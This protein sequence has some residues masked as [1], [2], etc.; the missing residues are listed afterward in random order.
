MYKPRSAIQD[1]RK[2]SSLSPLPADLGCSR[3]RPLLSGRSRKHPTSAGGE[4]KK[5]SK[6]MRRTWPIVVIAG[7][8]VI[9]LS[10]GVRQVSGL[11]LR[12]VAIDIG[13]S[14]EAFGI[15]VAL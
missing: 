7:S 6:D 8:L 12:P 4:G 11:F 2:G 10:M 13:L 1:G 14:R 3:A 5:G 15:A 9:T